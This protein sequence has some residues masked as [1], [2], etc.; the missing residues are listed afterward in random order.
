MTIILSIQTILKNP[1]QVKRTFRQKEGRKQ[2][3][4]RTKPT[5][6]Q[7]SER[8]KNR[9]PIRAVGE[10]RDDIARADSFHR[11]TWRFQKFLSTPTTS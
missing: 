3:Y 5:Q 8:G 1:I 7:Y 9:E 11:D 6:N 10:F 4:P 2:N